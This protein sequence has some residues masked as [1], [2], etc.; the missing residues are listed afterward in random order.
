MTENNP[1]IGSIWKHL[2]TGGLYRVLDHVFIEATAEPAVLYISMDD[3]RKWVR[4]TKEFL[5]GRF[6]K[7]SD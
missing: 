5:D 6:E 2:K 1:K 7:V 3:G 4:P